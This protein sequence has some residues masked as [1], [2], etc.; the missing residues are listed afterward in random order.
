MWKSL[1]G[2]K[3]KAEIARPPKPFPDV[4]VVCGERGLARCAVT[5]ELEGDPKLSADGDSLMEL[6]VTVAASRVMGPQQVTLSLPYCDRHKSWGTLHL[7]A[8]ALVAVA[9]VNAAAFFA[10][11]SQEVLKPEWTAAA[12]LPLVVAGPISAVLHRMTRPTRLRD[13]STV[14]ITLVGVSKNFADELNREQAAEVSQ[15]IQSLEKPASEDV[16]PW[17]PLQ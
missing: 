8:T 10:L 7:W 3:Y 16:L 14:L 17:A 4:C 12:L 9:G 1:L 11:V 2:P 5:L 15:S 13:I 6:A